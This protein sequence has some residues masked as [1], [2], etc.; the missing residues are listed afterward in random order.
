MG[1]RCFP[2]WRKTLNLIAR[3]TLE[4]TQRSVRGGPVSPSPFPLRLIPIVTPHLQ[5]GIASSHNYDGKRL[6]C[7]AEA[8]ASVQFKNVLW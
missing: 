1:L 4:A 8:G 2:G 6:P 5:I 7:G 3:W